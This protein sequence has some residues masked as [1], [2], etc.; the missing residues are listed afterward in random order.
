MRLEH[1][2]LEEQTASS[3]QGGRAGM[4]RPSP[5]PGYYSTCS[6]FV[7]LSALCHEALRC[8]ESLV[9]TLGRGSWAE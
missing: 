2:E 7:L 4:A 6:A 9:A 1:R 8:D 5:C 3:S